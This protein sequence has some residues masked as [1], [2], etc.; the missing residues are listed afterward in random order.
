[1]RLDKDY[2][3]QSKLTPG[4]RGQPFSA[5]AGSG[6]YAALDQWTRVRSS[7]FTKSFLASC[8]KTRENFADPVPF[9]RLPK[10]VKTEQHLSI[11]RRH[12]LSPPDREQPGYRDGLDL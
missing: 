3:G 5:L 10:G 12:G 2:W 11:A 7:S 8:L 6:E 4:R 9:A 1:M